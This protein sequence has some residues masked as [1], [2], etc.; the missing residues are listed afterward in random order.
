MSQFHLFPSSPCRH[1]LNK[2]SLSPLHF[3]CPCFTPSSVNGSV[4]RLSHIFQLSPSRFWS[5]K[6][7]F[8]DQGHVSL[9]KQQHMYSRGPCILVPLS[10]LM[11]SLD[12]L[13]E[14]LV[15][16]R[17]VV[18]H[19]LDSS[20]IIISLRFI[21]GIGLCSIWSKTPDVT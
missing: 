5:R 8:L 7:H 1:T 16:L 3:P 13:E 4:L 18:S 11:S 10:T 20:Y 2:V 12:H 19:M 15:P 9:C 21:Q 6:H 17:M 14:S